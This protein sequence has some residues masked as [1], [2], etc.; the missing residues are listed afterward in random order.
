MDF[1]RSASRTFSG[2]DRKGVPERDAA[3]RF[4]GDRLVAGFAARCRE[5]F[6]P[7]CRAQEGVIYPRYDACG[8][9]LLGLSVL[10]SDGRNF[11][12]A[13]DMVLEIW[14]T[15]KQRCIRKKVQALDASSV[16]LSRTL[17]PLSQQYTL[18][19]L[20]VGLSRIPKN[21]NRGIVSRITAVLNS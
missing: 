3:G 7:L 12:I 1:F 20:L 8:D 4:P 10:L 13:S 6:Q 15:T 19:E 14:D 16:T 18:E 9:A 2:C 11:S 5:H 21:P 17:S